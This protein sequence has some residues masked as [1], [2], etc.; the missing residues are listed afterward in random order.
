MSLVLSS[1]SF[2]TAPLEL[3]E[4]LSFPPEEQSRLLHWVSGQ[5][6]VS[7]AVLLC[8]CNRTELYLDGD[9]GTPWR[10]LCR[11]AELDPG[12][13][14][15]AFV[16]LTGEDA[17]RHLMEVA[18]GLC[19]QLRG[20]DQILSQVRRAMDFAQEQGVSDSNLS[21]LFRMAVT[22]GKQ[23]RT[24][25]QIPH[26]A[27]SAGE[28]T[29]ELLEKELGDLHGKQI[30]VIGNGQMGRLAAGMLQR[31]GADVTVTLRQYRHRDTV[32]PSGCRAVP[33]ESRMELRDTLDA[34]VTATTSPH[35]TVL[36]SQLEGIT[37]P[38]VLVDLAVPRDVEPGC[39]ELPGIRYHD[40][41]D[42]GVVLEMDE[43]TDRQIQDRIDTQLEA[44]ERWRRN[45][46]APA[47]PFRFPLFVDLR[48]KRVVLVGGG[49]IA[50]RRIGTLRQ[51]GCEIVVIAPELKAQQGGFTWLSRCYQPGDLKGAAIAI[52][53]TDSREVNHQ[54]GE[55]AKALG[56]PVSVADC[57]QECTFFFPAVCTGENVIAG[58][59]SRGRD[60]HLTALAA[61][62][63]RKVL[64]DLP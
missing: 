25:V 16:T 27:P 6:G 59:V 39:A 30:L 55:D 48:G 38:L 15:S 63:I 31:A 56:I 51:F 40:L 58:V 64:E 19:S 42:L 14:E 10:M 43:E 62:E 12:K 41:D 36:K 3:R 32:V 53:A 34:I 26:A 20:E 5:P 23:V 2:Q 8:T 4:Q 33:Y 46:S 13:L 50:S 28:K 18:C 60:H 22:V 47:E 57:E 21:V 35:Y 11:W 44:Y 1:L 52:A 29:V 61:K 17:A 54:V 24:Q 49:K 7:G 37:R 45:R 9:C